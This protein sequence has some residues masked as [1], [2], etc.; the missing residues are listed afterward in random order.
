MP[1]PLRTL[2]LSIFILPSFAAAKHSAILDDALPRQDAKVAAALR[3]S[4]IDAGE[5][6]TALKALDLN[7]PDA[8]SDVELLVL[9]SARSV[10]IAAMPAIDRFLQSGGK[11]IAC[12]MP[13]CEDR[14]FQADGKWV[15]DA[16]YRQ[17][18][19]NVKPTKILATFDAAEVARWKRA[20]NSDKPDVVECIK[21]GE[22]LALHVSM[23]QLIGWDSFG[24]S[25]DQPFATGNTLTCFRAKGSANTTQLAVEWEE[26]DGSRWLATV[27]LSSA[28]RNYALP[29]QAFAPWQPPPGRGGP[30]DSLNPHQARHFSAGLA[31]SHTQIQ[32]GAHEFWL[33]DLGT[34][35]AP[36]AAARPDTTIPHIE[37]LCPAYQFYPVAGAKRLRTP[38]SQTIVVRASADIPLSSSTATGMIALHPR[39]GGAGFAKNRAYRW[40]SLLEVESEKREY[41]GAIAAL[42]VPNVGPR[43]GSAW[44]C[45]TPGD[46][47]FYARPDVAQMITD[48]TRLLRR[49]VFLREGGASV[50]T[51]FGDLPVTVGARTIKTKIGSAGDVMVSTII[52]Q[53][54]SNEP[55]Y[56]KEWPV[57]APGASYNEQWKP[58]F[59]PE[60]G[61]TVTTELRCDDLLVDR[62]VHKLFGY[63]LKLQPKFVT[64]RD[65]GFMLDGKP[66]KP[67][68]VNYMPSSGIGLDDGEVF[69]HWI[70]SAGYDPDI[71]ERDLRRIRAMN[72]NAISVFIYYKSLAAWNLVD[73]LRRCDQI[74][75]K[76]NLSLRPGTPIDFD[77]DQWK[78]IIEQQ[79]LAKIDT[80]F[81][82][83]LAWEWTHWGRDYQQKNYT[84]SWR[85]WVKKK[86]G[87]TDAASAAWTIKPPRA[88]DGEL[89]VPES[90][91]LFND[92]EWRKMSADYRA[93]LDEFLAGRYGG[94]RDLVRSIDP[95]HFVSFRMN[96]AGD[97]T[98]HDTANLGYD[99]WGLRDAVD[100][101]EPEAYGRIGDYE[102]VKPG[103]FT[104][105][106][107]RLC[108]PAKPLIWAEVG[109]SAWDRLTMSAEPQ[110]LDFQAKFV[111]D[112]YRMMRESGSDGV[113][114]WWYPGGYRVNEMSD[115]GII[116][117]DGT[118][119]PVTKVIRQEGPA[120]IN[121]PRPPAPDYWISIDRDRDARG[122][123]GI[124][125]SVKDEYFKAIESKKTPGLKWAHPPAPTSQP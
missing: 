21:D 97:P 87:S 94:A 50:Y 24:R 51:Q 78:A 77:W 118:D 40:Q 16:E 96:V 111:R 14:V 44:V 123:F 38:E 91:Q 30:G 82:Y 85:K 20:T 79:R 49:G 57:G 75:L 61:F 122:L 72:L 34:A 76:V 47:E 22:H 31:F 64:A 23:P 104:V 35:E 25:F 115:F 121:A 112:F 86:Y 55:V 63:Q 4:L 80:V 70:G 28:W 103:R 117:P 2:A 29:P 15:T 58:P 18:V 6:P 125:Q 17:A 119:R 5:Q 7:A 8:L 95:N 116:N 37:G 43:A 102:W 53:P 106:Y 68:G 56:K 124:Y 9:P 26:S 10:P 33:A 1:F 81:A 11:L 88:A 74:G 41:R 66:W 113:F 84:T 93:F 109:V 69:E 92:G 54:G 101:Y 45:F 114:F 42:V 120:F 105:S 19:E 32:R 12:G 83:D 62:L 89:D 67:N 27:P 46:A 110:K 65:G 108:N 107:A 71:V 99:F 73:L 52:T 59:W 90:A 100:I 60:Q 48:V 13:L 39:P 36:L 3:Q 98:A